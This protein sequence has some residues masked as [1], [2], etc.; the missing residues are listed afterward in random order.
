MLRRGLPQL[1]PSKVWDSLPCKG[2]WDSLASA[3]DPVTNSLDARAACDGFVAALYTEKFS[4]HVPRKGGGLADVLA[5]LRA[6][7]LSDKVKQQL[8]SEQRV[9]V[10]IGNCNW[11]M[12]YWEC[13]QP[14]EVPPPAA[15][16][17]SQT[18]EGEAA[19]KPG[20]GAEAAVWDY[21]VCFPDPLCEQYGF[22]KSGDRK[23][24]VQ[25]WDCEGG[26]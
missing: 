9:W 18:G 3:Y 7:K 10:T 8:P 19:A 26:E 20:E 21:S 4:N 13:V 17:A 14:R 12:K 5:Q 25:W 22:R 2:V 6:S 23:D 11:L 1:G 15:A 16:G 24:A